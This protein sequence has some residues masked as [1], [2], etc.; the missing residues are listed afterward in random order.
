MAYRSVFF[1]F[2]WDQDVWRA[3]VVRNCGVTLGVNAAGFRDAAEIEAVK[4]RSDEAIKHWIDSQL[5]GTTVTVVLLG[6]LTHQS[7]WVK[8]ECDAS[9]AR[10]NGIIF[11]DISGIAD[12]Y[13]R[14]TTYGGMP[15][16]WP[17]P[18]PYSPG[19]YLF[20]QWDTQLSPQQFGTWIEQA[21]QNVGK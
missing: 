8:Y 19:P 18:S 21:A 9:I 1:S 4:Y 17:E 20:R 5:N 3:M 2:D 12:Q 7:R 14:T 11:I 6:A 13:R 16:G 10:G 15:T